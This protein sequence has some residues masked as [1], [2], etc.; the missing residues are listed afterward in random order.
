ME[1]TSLDSIKNRQGNIL[2]NPEDIAEK[3]YIL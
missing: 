2:T 1:N 3:I